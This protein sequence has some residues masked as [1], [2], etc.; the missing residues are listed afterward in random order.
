MNAPSH[1]PGLIPPGFHASW[2]EVDMT[3]WRWPNFSPKEL[4]CKCAGRYCRGEYFH[5]EAFLDNLEQLRTEAGRPIALTSARRCTGHNRAV[6]GA[7][8]SQHMLRIAG[9]ID[10]DGHE[11]VIL[12]RAAVKA[13]FT[14]I[15]F[16][17][18]FLHVDQREGRVAWN[19]SAN[20]IAFWRRAFGF[21]PVAKLKAGWTL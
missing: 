1:K 5:D 10:L 9:D 4:A 12:A 6:G 17:N 16:G 8:R 2:A 20:A 11:A 3:G 19:Y 7:A 21:D 13:G 18:G 14:G 15:G